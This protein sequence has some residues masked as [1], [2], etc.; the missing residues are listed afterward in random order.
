MREMYMREVA[1]VWC[2]CCFAI[3]NRGDTEGSLKF[4]G[5]FINPEP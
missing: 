4:M 3:T 1:A 5:E 2:I